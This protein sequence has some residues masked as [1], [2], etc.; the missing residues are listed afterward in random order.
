MILGTN[1]NRGLRLKIAIAGPHTC[2]IESTMACRGFYISF[3]MTVYLQ[4]DQR[5]DNSHE[6]NCQPCKCPAKLDKIA[7]RPDVSLGT[8][9]KHSGNDLWLVLFCVPNVCQGKYFVVHLFAGN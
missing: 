9:Y 7:F 1:N 6:M 5:L 4:V 8:L 2:S 3:I